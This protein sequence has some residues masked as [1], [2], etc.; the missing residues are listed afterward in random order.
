MARAPRI[1]DA[2]AEAPPEADRL[3]GWPH[4]RDTYTVLGHDGAEAIIAEAARSGKSIY[5]FGSNSQVL[6]KTSRILQTRNTGLKIA[7]V[8]APPLGFDPASEDAR[9]CIETIGESGAG[10]GAQS[11]SVAGA[12]GALRAD[13][14]ADAREPS[15]R[16]MYSSSSLEAQRNHRVDLRRPPRREVTRHQRH[17]H[18]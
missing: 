8:F 9:R 3:D 10:H 16:A 7:G 13:L 1:I 11:Q 17:D 5:L 6:N 12:P 15:A 4:P 18:Q 2:E 14:G